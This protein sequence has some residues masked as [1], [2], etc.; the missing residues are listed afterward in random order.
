[1]LKRRFIA[2]V[3]C[4]RCAGMDKIVMYDTEDGQ[5]FRECVSC[6]FKEPFGSADAAVEHAPE[7]VKTRVNQPRVGEKTLAHEV[8]VQAVKFVDAGIKRKDH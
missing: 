5:R 3:V 8:E 7:E 1:M 2:G 4:P 6:G